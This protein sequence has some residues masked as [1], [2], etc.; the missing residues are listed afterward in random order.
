MDRSGLLEDRATRRNPEAKQIATR[1]FKG[2]SIGH[3]QPELILVSVSPPLAF[4]LV[5]CQEPVSADQAAQVAAFVV[6]GPW[7]HGRKSARAHELDTRCQ[8]R[9]PQPTLLC[10]GDEL[11]SSVGKEP[12]VSTCDDLR[13]V[14]ERDAVGWL[15]HSPVSEH[16]GRN[17]PA[18][19]PAPHGPVDLITHLNLLEQAYCAIGHED[20]RFTP[21][22]EGAGMGASPVRI[23]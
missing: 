11:P 4:I 23:D 5:K 7:R 1:P 8:V 14:F 17:V 20:G 10:A 9:P 16:E 6:V 12:V 13:S 2:F 3:C 21:Y 19:G 22:T 15:A 18:V